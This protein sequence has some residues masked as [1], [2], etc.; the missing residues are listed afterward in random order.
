MTFFVNLVTKFLT[1]FLLGLLQ[2]LRRERALRDLGWQEADLEYLKGVNNAR[3]RMD[4]ELSRPASE[5][6]REHSF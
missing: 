2:D 4:M 6:L 3:T 1:G 5:R